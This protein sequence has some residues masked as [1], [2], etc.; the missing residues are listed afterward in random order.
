M[1]FPLFKSPQSA[2]FN[3]SIIAGVVLIGG[4]EKFDGSG[5]P[6]ATPVATARTSMR[7][8]KGGGP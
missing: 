1:P 5:A 3:V 8:R 6:Q 7:K 2:N 4:W